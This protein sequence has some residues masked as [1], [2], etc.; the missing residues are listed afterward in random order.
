MVCKSKF[1]AALWVAHSWELPRVHAQCNVSKLLFVV[2]LFICLWP[3]KLT[4]SQLERGP[5]KGGGKEVFL[6]YS[7]NMVKGYEQCEVFYFGLCLWGKEMGP[8]LSTE[9]HF[10]WNADVLVTAGAAKPLNRNHI[11]RVARQGDLMSLNP[12]W[13]WSLHLSPGFPSW[14]PIKR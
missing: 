9:H 14:F 2:F 10:S 12:W 11:L 5:R 4:W 3:V 7:L 8:L 1:S 13:L 6:V